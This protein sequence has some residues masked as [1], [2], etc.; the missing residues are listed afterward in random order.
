VH[1]FERWHKNAREQISIKVKSTRIIQRLLNSALV[2]GF[3]RW[4]ERVA[5]ERQLKGKAVRVVLRWTKQAAVRC[6]V[7]WGQLTAQEVR[8]RMVMKKVAGRMLNKSLCFAMDLWRLH[9][10]ALKQGQAEEARRQNIMSK[11]VQRMLKQAQVAAFGQWCANVRELARQRW[12]MERVL[13]RMLNAKMCAGMYGG[14]DMLAFYVHA[15]CCEMQ[16]R[17]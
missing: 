10:S 5:V 2:E 4:Q 7:A 1:C 12:S 6:L 16:L 3:E 14:L 11:V 9:V 17:F 8:K 13:R 15:A